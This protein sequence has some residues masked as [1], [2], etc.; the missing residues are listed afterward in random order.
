[1]KGKHMT[2]VAL[3]TGAGVGEGIALRL[4]KAGMAVGVLD[5][6]AADAE[7]VSADIKAKGG[8]A[9]ALVADVAKTDQVSAAVE[10][11]RQAFG[12]VNVLV[13]NAGII[14]IIPFMELSVDQWDRTFEV[15][16]RG[17][18]N[19]IQAVLPDMMA[20][21][22]GRIINISSS[23][24]QTGASTLV[25]YASSKAAIW[26]LTRSLALEFGAYGITVNNI[27]PAAIKGTPNWERNKDRAPFPEEQFFKKIAVGR[28]GTPEDIG[29]A[30][31]W[32]ASEESG[33][34]TG[35]TIGL[36]GG[37]ISPKDWR[38]GQGRDRYRQRQ[39]M[40]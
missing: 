38:A 33:Y 8:K 21:K 40:R 24:A 23:G 39:R 34:I 32:L 5:V 37:S 36:S 25:A 3:V 35:Q 15:N 13:N 14:Q 29:D 19:C 12:P 22:W 9:L 16:V 17:S 18:F 2:K 1:M 27:P 10:K 11:L 31:T 28:P 7:K 30:V 20:A 4:A 26:G 6:N